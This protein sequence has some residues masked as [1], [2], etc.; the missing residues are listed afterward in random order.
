MFCIHPLNPFCPSQT[1]PKN[2]T[3]EPKSIL[4]SNP[5]I[6]PRLRHLR[7]PP[8]LLPTLIIIEHRVTTLRLA[9][10]LLD[11]SGE[12]AGLRRARVGGRGRRVGAAADFEGLVVVGFVGF[13]A[14]RGADCGR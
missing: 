14:L 1:P 7:G 6:R 8:L 10:A 3:Q 11:A 13:A 5:S 2:K 12:R 9:R 4:N